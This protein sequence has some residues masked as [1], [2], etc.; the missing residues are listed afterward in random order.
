MPARQARIRSETSV[1]DSHTRKRACVVSVTTVSGWASTVAMRSGLSRNGS[2]WWPRRCR[3][4]MREG[5][6]LGADAHRAAPTAPP[7]VTS[8]VLA[9]EV[10]QILQHLVGGGD[11]A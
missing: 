4:I 10:D 2:C 1:G 5:S 6:G 3:V 11:H 7:G 9:V 8:G